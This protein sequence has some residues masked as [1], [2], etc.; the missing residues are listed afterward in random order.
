M[1]IEKES[2]F[3]PQTNKKKNYNIQK[4]VIERNADFIYKKNEKLQKKT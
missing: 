1:M 2:T 3:Q 4:D